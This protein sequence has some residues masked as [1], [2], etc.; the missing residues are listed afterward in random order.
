M[1]AFPPGVL[2]P[3]SGRGRAL[4]PASDE[5]HTLRKLRGTSAGKQSCFLFLKKNRN[6]K[7]EAAPRS[8]RDIWKLVGGDIVEPLKTLVWRN[9]E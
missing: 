1:L 2:P 6:E 5:A 8:G 7:L 9:S 3:V 4:L